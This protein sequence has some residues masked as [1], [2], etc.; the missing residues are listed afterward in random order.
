[1]VRCETVMRRT[2]ALSVGMVVSVLAPAPEVARGDEP[3]PL[4]Q[5]QAMPQGA[6]TQPACH[7]AADVPRWYGDQ[8]LLVD[9]AAFAVA[10]VSTAIWW[11]TN[12]Q[13]AAKLAWVALGSWVLTGPTV[14]AIN[15]G[16]ANYRPWIS[17]AMRLAAPLAGAAI[18]YR[19][20]NDPHQSL[21]AMTGL[22]GFLL[23]GLAGIALTTA[24]DVVFLARMPSDA[25]SVTQ[26]GVAVSPFVLA[27]SPGQ[28]S[29]GGLALSGAF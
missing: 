24:A 22:G 25:A 8:M 29:V 5:P 16:A 28:R 23:G 7:A 6:L 1:M 27:P 10:G 4:A 21:D 15:T 19:V 2:V 26:S 18:G 17:L 13:A 11:G 9:G 12:N 3:T 14:H 20:T